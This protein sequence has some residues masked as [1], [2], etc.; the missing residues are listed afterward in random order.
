M[1]PMYLLFTN[2]VVFYFNILSLNILNKKIFCSIWCLICLSKKE[3]SIVFWL[4]FFVIFYKVP[5]RLVKTVAI[6]SLWFR[7]ENM[8]FRYVYLENKIQIR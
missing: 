3:I 8:N 5:I 4:V 1:L 7:L 2:K 6:Y